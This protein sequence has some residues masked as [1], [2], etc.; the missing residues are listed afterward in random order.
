[1]RRLLGDRMIP[2]LSFNRLAADAR[3]AV[4]ELALIAAGVLATLV[5]LGLPVFVG[6]IAA[7][8]AWDDSARGWLASAD[9]AGSALATLLVMPRI[10]ELDW[11]RASRIALAAAAAGNLASPFAGELWSL[12]AIR[13]VTGTACG[14]VVSIT[15]TG[16]CQS[17]HPERFFGLYTLTQLVIQ[18]LVLAALPLIIAAGGTASVFL[19]FAAVA[20]ASLALVAFFPRGLR[21]ARAAAPGAPAAPPQETPRAGAAVALVAQAIYFLS[22]AA[23]W[24]Y[25]EGIGSSF[26]LELAEIG[27]ALALS[28]VA[29]IGGALAVI[30]LGKSLPRAASLAL[31]TAMSVMSAWLL[32]A[33]GGFVRFALSACLFNFAW[34]YTFPYQMGLLARLDRRGT[35][36]VTSLL[37]QY[38]GLAGGPALA[39]LI[40]AGSGYGTLLL[41]GIAGYALS[42]ALFLPGARR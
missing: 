31:G 27:R 30:A 14:V 22:V 8:F 42:L 9:M 35:L 5:L 11:R 36:A 24:G 21:E 25:Y 12:C 40:L 28:A 18:A 33:D 1:M 16:L 17:R 26:G 6:G 19:L 29:G 39:A 7:E 10:A 38:A 23:I 4:P 13:F 2:S 37:V 3:S 20:A 32:L 34:N 15:F 41:A